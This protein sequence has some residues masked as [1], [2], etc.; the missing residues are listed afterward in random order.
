MEWFFC[1]KIGQLNWSRVTSL[2]L[3][4]TNFRTFV[5]FSYI[6]WLIQKPCCFGVW[7][8]WTDCFCKKASSAGIWFQL[9]MISR[10]YSDGSYM[11]HFWTCWMHPVTFISF[12]KNFASQPP[13][14]IVAKL[15]FPFCIIY[16]L[17]AIYNIVS[18]IEMRSPISKQLYMIYDRVLD[19]L[20]TLKLM[21]IETWIIYF[22]FSEITDNRLSHCVGID[23]IKIFGIKR[24][25]GK[26]TREFKKNVDWNKSFHNKSG[27]KS[28]MT[29][30][31]IIANHERAIN[32]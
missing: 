14:R 18:N 25:L 17:K 12:S 22:F 15:F 21:N 9:W 4:W 1:Q 30:K 19:F 5:Q 13:L 3:F 8:E 2:S 20:S 7:N 6:C 23:L 10:P 29:W 27:L 16:I 28:Q 31:I 26:W 11:D 24:N 32:K